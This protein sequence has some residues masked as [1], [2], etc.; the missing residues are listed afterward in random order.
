M[1]KFLSLAIT[2]LVGV[3]ISLA[4]PA[5]SQAGVYAP[6]RQPQ[7]SNAAP[8]YFNNNNYGNFSGN[9]S[10]GFGGYGSG[11]GYYGGYGNSGYGLGNIGYGFPG[12][13][14][15]GYG[16]PGYNGGYNTYAN[17]FFTPFGF[18]SPYRY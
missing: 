8:S 6:G 4:S 15:N 9:F 1:N 10:Y 16:F 13:G 17:P 14:Y 18:A 7:P 3:G 2:G 12:Y 5:V 11:Y